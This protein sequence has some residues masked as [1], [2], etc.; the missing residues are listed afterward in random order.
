MLSFQALLADS[1]FTRITLVQGDITT[2]NVNAVVNAANSSLLG[3]SEVD[4]ATAESLKDGTV[5]AILN[6]LRR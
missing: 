6:R 3:G 2:Q 1:A 4:G 5:Q